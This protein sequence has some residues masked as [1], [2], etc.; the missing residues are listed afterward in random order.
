LAVT[1]TV[2]PAPALAPGVLG[3]AAL[4]L[5]LATLCQP[6]HPGRRATNRA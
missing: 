1:K 5:L 4:L 3:Q 2:G 6:E